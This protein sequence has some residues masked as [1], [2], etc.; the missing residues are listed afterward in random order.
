M[1]DSRSTTYA[2]LG[3]T[4]LAC[5]LLG[6]TA[7]GGGADP[8][9][10]PG[11]V[12]AAMPALSGDGSEADTT[13]GAAPPATE[14]APVAPTPE[15]P[16]AVPFRGI[17]LAGAEFGKVIPGVEG[18]D[19][20]FPKPE[21]ID[22]FVSKGMNTFRVGFLWERLQPTAGGELTAEYGAK[23]DAVIQHITAQGKTAILNPHNFARYYGNPIGSAAVPPSTFADLWKR[24]AT[25]YGQNPRVMFN[26]VNEPN[27]MPTEDWVSG[28]NAAIAA[29]RA[30][31]ATNTIIVPGNGW[32]GGHSWNQNYY[33]TPNA[34][35]M[36][37]VVDPANNMI[38]EAHQYLDESAAGASDTCVSATAGRERLAPFVEWLRANG[39]KGFVGE[40]AGANNP[41]CKA[42]IADMLAYV[43][44]SSDVLVGWTWWAAG[45]WESTYRFSLERLPGST[46]DRVQ[47]AWLTPRL[48]TTTS[49]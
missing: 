44:E 23:L 47:M 2:R 49:P 6:L 32:T 40:L 26:L 38:F 19:Y 9:A 46:A 45:P 31:G 22:Y 37:N 14:P 15:T 7:C 36:L 33:G 39:K 18:I 1:S 24:L 43:A 35:A 34:V 42:A 21:S 27:N 41:T 25:R 48:F 10:E 17:N 4:F 5:T 12:S 8:A 3:A 13:D 28:A 30:A 16:Q 29:I 11:T 20:R